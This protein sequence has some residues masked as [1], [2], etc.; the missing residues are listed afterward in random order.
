MTI[1][2]EIREETTF[3]YV[4]GLIQNGASVELIAKSFGLSR[5]KVE[6]IIKKIKSSA[7]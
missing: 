3:N 2:D 1:A 5:Q 7:N 6:E 4:K